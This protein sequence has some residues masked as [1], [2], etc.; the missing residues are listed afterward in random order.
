MPR[1]K[2]RPLDE[3]H[4]NAIRN[5]FQERRDQRAED[6]EQADPEEIKRGLASA[7]REGR[8]Y[9]NV[10]SQIIR[11]TPPPDDKEEEE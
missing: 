3:N 10:V 4:A 1:P 2:G 9:P 7:V 5:A 6:I 8:L 11:L